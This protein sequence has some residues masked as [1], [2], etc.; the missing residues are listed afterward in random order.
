VNPLLFLAPVWIAF[1]LWQLVVA[2]RYLGVERIEEGEDPRTLSLSAPKAAFWSLGI[3]AEWLWIAVMLFDWLGFAPAL[4][5]AAVSGT[6]YLLRR[7]TGLRWTLVILTFEGA[8][9]IGLLFFL[10]AAL[11]IRVM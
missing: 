8:I 4:C 11:W 10:V 3:M 9:R 1:E 7:N 5:M 6:G 2:E